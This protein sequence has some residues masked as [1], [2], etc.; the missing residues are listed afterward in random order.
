MIQH[1]QN[2]NS[3]HYIKEILIGIDNPTIFELGVHWGEDTRRIMNLCKSK[4]NYHG[5]EPDPR[6]IKRIKEN[7]LP[8]ELKLNE[9]AVSDKDGV[10]DFYLSGG[11]HPVNGNL[12]TG[13]NSIRMPKDVLNKH[14]WISFDDVIKVKTTYLDKYCKENSIDKIDFMWCDI[15][16][17]E[18]DM[19]KGAKDI[20]TKTK[21]AFLE[22]SD[23][24]LYLG[25]KKIK[26]YMDLL[27]DCGDWEVVH[28]F[29]IDILL[30][31]KKASS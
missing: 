7:K 26:D 11:N 9:C 8:Y 20:L 19:I 6:N 22:Y 2:Y 30:Q 16:G 1:N 13:A 4:P 23:S 21:Y 15:Q 17:A 18:Y 24:E 12:M 3:W 25:Q 10:I 5:F 29:D 31:N 28:V 27:S 14:S